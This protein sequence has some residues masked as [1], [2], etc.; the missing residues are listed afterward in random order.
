ME[1]ENKIKNVKKSS[2]KVLGI[3]TKTINDILYFIKKYGVFI[4]LVAT[5]IYVYKKFISLYVNAF[6][7]SYLLYLIYVYFGGIFEYLI[8]P[9]KI[10]AIIFIVLASLG[11]E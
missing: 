2:D 11:R 6:I 1:I 5:L 7:L 3:L 8:I 4:G 10:W 9:F